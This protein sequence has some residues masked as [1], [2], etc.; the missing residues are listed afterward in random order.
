MDDLLKL[1]AKDS[2]DVQVISAVLQDSIAPVSDMLFE[3]EAKKFI[4]VVHRLKRDED[5]A[6]ERI[7]CAFNIHG[8]EAAQMQALDLNNPSQILD[9]LMVIVDNNAATFIFA[10]AAKIRLQLKDWS[11]I[12]EDFGASWPAQCNPCHD[13]VEAVG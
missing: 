9:L 5:G 11:M 4:M 13:S 10:G 6:R 3:A 12:I 8:V 2:E 1:K 7:C